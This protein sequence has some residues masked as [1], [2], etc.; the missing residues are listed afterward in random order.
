VPIRWAAGG[1]LR[2]SLNT[3]ERLNLRLDVGVGPDTYGVYFTAR[4]AF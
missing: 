1:G 4:E 3:E 2:L